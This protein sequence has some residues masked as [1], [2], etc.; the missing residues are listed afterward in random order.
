MEIDGINIDLDFIEDKT[1]SFNLWMPMLSELEEL[2]AHWLSP[3]RPD[4]KSGNGNATRRSPAAVV[5]TPAPWEERLG[6]ALELITVKTLEATTQLW[7]S[8]V[9]VDKREAPRQHR[10]K[11]VLALHPKRL[12]GRT[13]SDTF[14]SSIKSIRGFACIQIFFICLS[15]FIF[16]RGIR[17]ESESHGAYQDMVREV[18]APNILLTDN[19]QTQVGKKWRKMSQDNV[20]RQVKTVPHNQNQN[21][22][23]CK[24]QDVKRRTIIT[25]RYA[26]APL[27]FWCYCMYFI[28][29][30]QNGSAQKELG[31]RSEGARV[32][33]SH[34]EDVRP[35][36]RH[37]HVQ[38][39]FLGADLV[40]RTN[41]DISEQQLPTWETCWYR[42]GTWQ[43]VYL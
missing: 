9:E 40:F 43:C 15:K 39:S 5:P 35:D 22:V 28:V 37:I 36:S 30:C 11:R 32:S 3:R 16:V 17:K 20:T 41:G 38:V 33:D 12:E 13:D 19:A 27:V 4:L 29:N 42:L 23:E 24:I 10:K 18:G 2:A 8:P 31:Y 14:F 1:L 26:M 21:Q 6:N 25:L 34:G 7:E